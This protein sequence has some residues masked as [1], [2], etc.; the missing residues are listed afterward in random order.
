MDNVLKIK[1]TQENVPVFRKS[2][3]EDLGNFKDPVCVWLQAHFAKLAKE[4][5]EKN[6]SDDVKAVMARAENREQE[7]NMM[8]DSMENKQG[9]TPQKTFYFNFVLFSN[10][11]SLFS[12]RKLVLH[13]M[14]ARYQ[15]S[16]E[17]IL[18]I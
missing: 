6:R 18:P 13:F 10:F 4:S 17:L 7:L 11:L 12:T 9:K 16:W 15:Q 3:Y 8:I 14:I 1:S 5:I 2:I